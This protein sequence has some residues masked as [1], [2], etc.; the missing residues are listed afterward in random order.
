MTKDRTLVRNWLCLFYATLL[1][2]LFQGCLSKT[3]K[4]APAP[5]PDL[6]AGVTAT[7]FTFARDGAD[8]DG[9]SAWNDVSPLTEENPWYVALPFNPLVYPSDDPLRQVSMKNRWVEVTS[10]G[11]GAV[12]YAQ[13]E[14]VGPW[15]VNDHAYVFDPAERP[16]AESA[17]GSGFDIYRAPSAAR[18]V[19]NSA[20]IDLSP[21]VAARLGVSGTALVDWRFV[22]AAAVPDGPWKEKVSDTPPHWRPGSPLRAFVA[23]D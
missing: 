5:S 17:R 15:F 3:E 21:A 2:F 23:R 4:E 10:R 6:H 18:I 22:E 7:W 16:F 20:G 19:R 11:D 13:V 9:I 1:L 12:A 8:A 14:D